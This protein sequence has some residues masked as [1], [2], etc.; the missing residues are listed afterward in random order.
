MDT[1]KTS[2]EMTIAVIRGRRKVTVMSREERHT[3]S[4]SCWLRRIWL[5]SAR[6][7][8]TSADEEKAKGGIQIR[9]M[10]ASDAYIDGAQP[11]S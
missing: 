9:I 10:E 6:P 1:K 2:K 7:A 8:K 3:R 4:D 11:K 5:R